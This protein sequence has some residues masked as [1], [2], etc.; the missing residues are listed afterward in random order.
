MTPSS[1]NAAQA[2]LPRLAGSRRNAREAGHASSTPAAAP[3]SAQSTLRRSTDQPF[4]SSSL[5]GAGSDACTPALMPSAKAGQSVITEAM[6]SATDSAIAR[7]ESH[8]CD[9]KGPEGRSAV[10]ARPA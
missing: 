10:T 8:G 2:W 6:R 1:T 3:P 5:A 4:A 9:G 7:R